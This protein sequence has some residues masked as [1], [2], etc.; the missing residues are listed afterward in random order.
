MLDSRHLS[1]SDQASGL[2]ESS[3]PARDLRNESTFRSYQRISIMPTTRRD[4]LLGSGAL[5]VGC[6][7]AEQPQPAANAT[8]PA[9]S[10]LD[11]IFLAHA[12]VLPEKRGAGANHDPMA[13]EVLEAVGRAGDIPARWIQRARSYPDGERLVVP[14]ANWSQALG[15]YERYEDWRTCFVHELATGSWQGVVA[16]WVP[17]L[18]PGLS[19]ALFHGLLR[20]AH[21][22]RAL[23]RADDPARRGELACGLAYWAARAQP[24]RHRL[25][26]RRSRFDLAGI[27]TPWSHDASDV[28]FDDVMQ[29]VHAEPLAPEPVLDTPGIRPAERLDAIVRGATEAFLEMIVQ[30]RNTIWLLHAVTGPAAVEILLPVLDAASSQSLVAYAEQACVAVFRAYGAPFEPRA[31]LRDVSATWQELFDRAVA[32]ESVHSI[33]LLEALRRFEAHGDPLARAVAVRWLES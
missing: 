21:A 8:Y 31:S 17:R 10:S 1:A 5:L 3:L 24:L 16:R 29:R 6:R 28:P 9:S 23:R 7:S 27:D 2:E 25:G 22:V 33:K 26:E 13:A 14:I 15:H 19:G 30:R 11:A 12:K 32:L 18:A 4:F 20:T